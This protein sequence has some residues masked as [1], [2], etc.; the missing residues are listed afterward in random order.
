MI[1]SLIR[2]NVRILL[3]E[4]AADAP[5][6]YYDDDNIN[7]AIDIAVNQATMD[8]PH[9]DMTYRVV[10]TIA[11]TQRYALDPDFMSLRHIRILIDSDY[12]YRM[13]QMDINEFDELQDGTYTR[14]GQPTHYKIELGVADDNTTDPQVPGDIWLS[15]IPDGIYTLRV[16]YDQRTILSSDS[17]VP[18]IPEVAHQAIVYYAAMFMS[19]KDGNQKK[20]NNYAAMY[21]QTIFDTK[22]WLHKR[23]GLVGVIPK[24]MG[25]Y[26][27]RGGHP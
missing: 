18:G 22:K 5:T 26:A 12:S 16:Y 27:G 19:F 2:T 3:G 4:T 8:L 1:R 15:P 11:S 6:S 20:A 14:E 13:K 21:K 7:A 10:T 25:G 24:D 9:A 17:D 23:D